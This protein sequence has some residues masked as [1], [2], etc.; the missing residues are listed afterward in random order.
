MRK[1]LLT[2]LLTTVAVISL[3][4]CSSSKYSKYVTVGEY[5]NLKLTDTSGNQEATY[6]QDDID[7]T[8]RENICIKT[9]TL[10]KQTKKPI[11]DKNCVSFEGKIKVN[12]ETSDFSLSNKMIEEMSQ[13]E[14]LKEGLMGHSVGEKLKIKV[15]INGQSLTANVKITSVTNDPLSVL[16]DAWVNKNDEEYKSKTVK[17][18]KSNIKNYLKTTAE[19]TNKS[20]KISV[21]T[22]EIVKNSKVIKYPENAVS[23]ELKCA[24][25]QY[26]QMGKMYN[27]NIKENIMQQNNLKTD[28]EYETFL[29]KIAKQET[30]RNL[31][32]N[33]IAEI[34]KLTPSED[35]YKKEIKTYKKEHKNSYDAYE[36]V[37]EK[38]VKQYILNEKVE[39]WLYTHNTVNFETKK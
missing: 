12:K 4:G 27:I 22:N 18:Y 33:R 16:T 29:N 3:V 25:K 1:K 19:N 24:K 9:P 13:I 35:T 26:K 8:I 10:L 7:R 37:G 32:F 23:N 20:N 31:V 34:E 36:I 28:K 38:V 6:S 11:T 21:I 5:E 15:K 30:K 39:N 17:E 2:F 14:G